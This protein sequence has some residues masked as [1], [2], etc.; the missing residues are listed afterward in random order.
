MRFLS[1]IFCFVILSISTQVAGQDF[2]NSNSGPREDGSIEEQIDYLVKESN[3]YKTYK[4]IPKVKIQKLKANILDTLASVRG[5]L[6]EAKNTLGEK[7]N[8]IAS[9]N[10]RLSDLQSNLDQTNTEKNSISFL[11]MNMGKGAY[12]TLM[13]FIVAALASLLGFFI[14]KFKESN[15]DTVSTRKDYEELQKEFEEHRKRSLEREQKAMR[16]LQDELNRK[17]QV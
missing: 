13:W 14:F 7:N 17:S 9:L 5:K 2:L 1:I 15:I 11:G 12:K 6:R 4:V 8:S 10:T 16:K 3:N